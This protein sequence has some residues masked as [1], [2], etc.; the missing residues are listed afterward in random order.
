MPEL[1][2]V[3]VVRRGLAGHTL[4]AAIERVT[5]VDGRSVRRHLAGPVDFIQ[6]LE[7]AIIADICRRGKYDWVLLARDTGA[8]LKRQVDPLAQVIHLAMS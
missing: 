1:P 5:V 8:A 6:H 2:E 3:E 7:G 4:G